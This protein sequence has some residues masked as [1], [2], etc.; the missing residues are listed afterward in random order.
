M[1]CP[2]SRIPSSPATLPAASPLWLLLTAA[3]PWTSAH[4]RPFHL[5]PRWNTTSPPQVP[6]TPGRVQGSPALV[7][8]QRSHQLLMLQED[9][10]ALFS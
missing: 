8:T 10:T 6:R 9:E 2:P 5:K 4:P 3:R 7:Q 1:T